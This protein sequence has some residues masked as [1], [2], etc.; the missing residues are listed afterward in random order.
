M[1]QAY[2]TAKLHAFMNHEDFDYPR[3]IEKAFKGVKKQSVVNC[4]RH[5]NGIMQI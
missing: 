5:A 3:Q 2:K 1:K 4:I